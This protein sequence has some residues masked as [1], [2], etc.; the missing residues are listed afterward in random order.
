M[1]LFVSFYCGVLALAYLR[2]KILFIGGVRASFTARGLTIYNALLWEYSYF[3][4]LTFLFVS[5]CGTAFKGV[6][7]ARFGPCLVAKGSFGMI[8]SRF[9]KGVD[10]CLVPIFRLRSR[11]DIERDL[12]GRAVL[13]CY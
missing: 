9:P 10:D 3:R 5:G 7:E 8:R 6:V 1:C 12:C 4:V 11:R 13:L 2:L